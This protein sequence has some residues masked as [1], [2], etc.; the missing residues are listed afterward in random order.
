MKLK[1]NPCDNCKQVRDADII[2]Y[3]QVNDNCYAIRFKCPH[4]KCERFKLLDKKQH[5]REI[6]K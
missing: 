1:R 3:Q 5:D 2:Q 6:L 4:C